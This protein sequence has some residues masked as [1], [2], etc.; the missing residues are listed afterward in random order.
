MQRSS[1]G[2]NGIYLLKR[3]GHFQKGRFEARDNEEA[4]KEAETLFRR[5]GKE[6]CEECQAQLQRLTEALN[7]SFVV[8]GKE[9]DC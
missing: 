2:K 6:N 3:C 7:K 5:L 4:Q 9:G 1:G 8:P